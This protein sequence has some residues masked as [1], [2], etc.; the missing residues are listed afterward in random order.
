MSEIFLVYQRNWLAFPKRG[1]EC[2]F[3]L[4]RL[5]RLDIRISMGTGLE[6]EP[7]T[8]HQHTFYC[9]WNQLN[10]PLHLTPIDFLLRYTTFFS[11]LEKRRIDGKTTK[12]HFISKKKESNS[13]DLRF[14]LTT[15][16]HWCHKKRKKQTQQHPLSQ[17]DDRIEGVNFSRNDGADSVGEYIKIIWF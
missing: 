12:Q 14:C 8:W 13:D 17:P 9:P 10:Y 2:A 4:L 15:L 16:W 1:T 5:T 11:I 3:P 7:S 6:L